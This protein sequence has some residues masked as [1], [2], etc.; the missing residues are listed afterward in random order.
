MPR[1]DYQAL[2]AQ[3]HAAAGQV[4]E[5]PRM[6][7][8]VGCQAGRYGSEVAAKLAIHAARSGSEQV[9]LV[10]ANA[11]QRRVARRFHLNGSPGLRELLSGETDAASCIHR[12]GADNLAVMTA[13]SRNGALRV[14]DRAR[15]V[16]QLQELKEQYGL[17]VVDLPPVRD[18]DVATPSAPWV[19]EVILVVE[20]EHT[21]IQ[22]ARRVKNQL[23]RA[24]ARV[25]GVVLE[26]RREY[27]PQ[28][29]YRRL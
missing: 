2:A 27:I 29:L 6:V 7:G 12:P 9:L 8:V 5:A 23:E 4:G 16:G 1:S 28:W 26:N 14:G 10:D 13:G 20:A 22:A 15:G 19:D 21:R 24:G 11:R 18:P 3:L 25:L 17:I